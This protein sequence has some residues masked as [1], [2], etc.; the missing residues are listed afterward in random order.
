[1]QIPETPLGLTEFIWRL[2][3]QIDQDSKDLKRRR[4]ILKVALHKL[5]VKLTPLTEHI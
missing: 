5:E 3:R 2:Q 4:R 1:M